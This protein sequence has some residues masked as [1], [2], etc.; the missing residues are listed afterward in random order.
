MRGVVMAASLVLGACGTILASCGVKLPETS[1]ACTLIGC[2]DQLTATVTGADGAIPP[3]M[4]LLTVTADAL[5]TTC[6]FKYPPDVLPSGG[7]V[8]PSCPQGLAVTVGPKTVCTET[9]TTST[10]TQTCTP[11][12]DQSVET[13]TVAGMPARVHV[14]QTMAGAS[15]LDETASPT[16]T[17]SQPNGPG[18][19]PTCHQAT[20]TWTFS[21]ASAA[22]P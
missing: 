16:Y 11:V 12:A 3:G 21:M 2:F 5:T 14:V 13:I 10:K 18:C 7:T 17:S 15:I 20:A 9:S 4:H 19:D 22:T 8:E 6:A 1:K